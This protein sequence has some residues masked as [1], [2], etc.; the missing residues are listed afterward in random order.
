MT[1]CKSQLT[2]QDAPLKQLIDMIRNS[3][4]TQSLV[5][6]DDTR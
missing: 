5:L 6:T 1:I 4:T 3:P 2:L